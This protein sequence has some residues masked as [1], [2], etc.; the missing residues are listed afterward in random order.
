ME[1]QGA[2]I[3]K[4]DGDRQWSIYRFKIHVCQIQVLHSYRNY[5]GNDKL[6]KKQSAQNGTHLLKLK[7]EI[8]SKASTM[9]QQHKTN[10]IYF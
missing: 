8:R 9:Q 4:C 6:K 10:S 3:Y 7:M 2:T 5:G 1:N